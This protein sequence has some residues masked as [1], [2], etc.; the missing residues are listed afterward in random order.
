MFIFA[1]TSDGIRRFVGAHRKYGVDRL[2]QSRNGLA[3]IFK[4]LNALSYYV[5][6]SAKLCV[7]GEFCPNVDKY[8]YYC[9]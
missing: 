5:L 3:I 2:G 4:M 6:F 8:R 9:Y 1:I 7:Y